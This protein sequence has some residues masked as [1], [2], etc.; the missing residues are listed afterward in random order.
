MEFELDDYRTGKIKQKRRNLSCVNVPGN[1]I[2]NEYD[3]NN[4]KNNNKTENNIINN[5]NEKPIYVNSSNNYIITKLKKENENLRF[6]LSKFESNTYNKYKP[7]ENKIRQK[8]IENAVRITK[9]I[10]NNKPSMTKS[11]NNISNFAN[12]TYTNNFYN[13]KDHRLKA[14]NTNN[15]S[16]SNNLN[17]MSESNINI[18]NLH[19]NIFN[20]NRMSTNSFVVH[21]KKKFKNEL[22]KSLSIYRS[23]SHNKNKNSSKKMLYDKIKTNYKKIHNNINN[24]ISNN[25]IDIKIKEK[26]YENN[27]NNINNSRIHTLSNNLY[28]NQKNIFSWKKKSDKEKNNNINSANSNICSTDRKKTEANISNSNSNDRNNIFIPN[29]EFN[30]TWS[31][32]QKKSIETSFDHYISEKNNNPEIVLSSKNKKINGNETNNKIG[33]KSNSKSKNKNEYFQ[34][35]INKHRKDITPQKITINRK[36]IN[37][38]VKSN[39]LYF[40]RS[41]NVSMKNII[42]IHEKNK[43]EENNINSKENLIS[44]SDS[45]KV[46]SCH[47]IHE[48]DIYVHKK[49]N[50]AFGIESKNNNNANYNI[51]HNI[52]TDNIEHKKN[53]HI[54]SK[55]NVTINNINNYNYINLIS[56]SNKPEFKN[57]KK[58]EK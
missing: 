36:M 33:A 46:L 37:N 55:Y 53:N 56:S 11:S 29:N 16:V 49:R 25:F 24:N 34:N 7:I 8:K 32:F 19:K 12:N 31:R 45:K 26:K 28:N 2:K 17:Q 47:N 41:N 21:T 48:G 38:K 4:K 58:K 57:S 40:G 51:N 18:K 43:K 42:N 3:Y 14:N 27:L 10:L 9:K 6:K 5:S 35:N 13:A 23:T 52:N 39:K 30:L 44:A 22:G 15:L 1:Y 50:S 20:Q 54:N